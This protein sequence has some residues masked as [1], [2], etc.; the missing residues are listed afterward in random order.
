M[1]RM[2]LPT[3]DDPF[4]N[5]LDAILADVAV[6]L[7]LPPSFHD[8]ATERYEAV[9][10]YAE[11]DGSPLKGHILRFYPQGSMA[12]DATI[13][14]RGTDDE[15]DIDIVAE[16]NVAHMADPNWALDQL[17]EALRGY[18]T[19]K[20]IERQTRC[21]TVRYA[22][23]MHLDVT[24]A[25]RLPYTA[26]RESHIFHAHPEKAASEHY[27]V[28]M[29]AYGFVEWYRQRTP[30]EDRFAKAFNRRLFEAYGIMIKAAA[31]VDEVPDPTPVHV[32]NTATVALQLLKR[33]RN[34]AYAEAGCR[35]PP[36]VMMSCF[37]G[38]AAAPN[39]SL[40]DMVIRQARMIAK[41]I[42]AASG[43]RERIK[44]VNPVYVHDCFTD[45]WPERIDQQN[46]F[47]QK[48]NEF[49][50]GLEY[51]KRNDTSL[52]DLQVWLRDQFGSHV[53]SRSIQQINER[54]G[55]AVLAATQSYTP[56]GGIYVPSAPKLMGVGAASAA[57][58]PSVAKAHTF[59]GGRR[60]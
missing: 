22:D 32:K 2:N 21:V 29:N 13:S 48:L 45:R 15:F 5:P 56:K 51:L 38:H 11:R 25:V 8:K 3:N 4:L 42:W 9:R 14:T 53:V 24:P 43:R 17:A 26:E 28:P 23:G 47:A 60:Q 10:T 35:I 33:F 58:M 30:I 39:T 36:S 54:M 55:R 7:Q 52:E 49:A 16:L 19:S 6:N 31:E 44:V 12:I 41:H 37:A 27:H 18:P 46:E 1:S 20:R 59:M 34:I 57:S 50:T 40:T